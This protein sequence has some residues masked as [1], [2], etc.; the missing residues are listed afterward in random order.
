M[1]LQPLIWKESL[2]TVWKL[3]NR[4]D[5]KKED[6]FIKL[7]VDDITAVFT[8]L[9]RPRGLPKHD[10]VVRYFLKKGHFTFERYNIYKIWLKIYESRNTMNYY[11]QIKFKCKEDTAVIK[12]W[13]HII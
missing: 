3:R 7:I 6:M 13:E 4:P 12:I 9:R 2:C 8:E 1:E 10:L 11:V 5:K